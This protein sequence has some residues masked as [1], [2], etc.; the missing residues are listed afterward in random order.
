[1]SNLK[2]YLFLILII[3]II[4]EESFPEENDVKVLTDDTFEE[5]LKK[6]DPLMVLFYAPWCSHSKSFQPE[7]SKAAKTLKK[8]NLIL[9]K[10]DASTNRKMAEKYQIKG[11]PTVYLFMKG[12][13]FEYLDARNNTNIIN[14]MKEK[15]GEMYKK[16][17][18]VDDLENLRKN[19]EVVLVYFGSDK[20]NIELINK[21]A[22][23]HD[24]YFDYQFVIAEPNQS[25]L[26]KY[27]V[28][29]GNFVL[30]KNYKED[31]SNVIFKGNL[32]EN[33]I[34]IFIIKY[35][36]PKMMKFTERASQ[37][38]FG[39][40]QP[41]LFLYINPNDKRYNKLKDLF[42]KIADEVTGKLQVIITGVKEGLETKLADYIG[43][44]VGELPC[45]KIADTRN[46]KLKKYNMDGEINKENIFEFISKWENDELNP[47]YKSETIPDNDDEL[48]FKL[49]GKNFKDE[50]LES[51]KDVLVKFYVPWCGHCK[52]LENKYIEVAQRLSNNTNLLIAEFDSNNN[53]I[54]SEEINSF[55]TIKLY[56]NGNK[57]NP[58]EY[59]GINN[60]ND[61]INF[62]KEN[63][64]REIFIEE[65]KKKRVI[66][67]KKKNKKIKDKKEKKKK[68]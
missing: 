34:N 28:K 4:T 27:Q 47:F 15:T 20:N 57:E 18:N 19:N 24:V 60:A 51:K 37:L 41:G 67:A 25:I 49:V 5:G 43:V 26:N 22:R 59:D 38:I 7:F 50:V 14:W 66:T 6:Y 3:G 62:V 44:S 56:R 35:A 32:L 53:E 16:L 65:K 1:M 54:E 17:N 8:D 42:T 21:V 11:F 23:N 9:A 39:Q 12:D 55:P 68:K 31:Q 64:G 48:I 29:E 58:I 36:L 30:Y 10:L 40:N 63:I 33:E 61:I 52:D 45:V 13:Q 2:N 46:G